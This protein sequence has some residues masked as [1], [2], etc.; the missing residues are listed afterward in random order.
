MN[1]ADGQEAA[2]RLCEIICSIVDER[3]GDLT[4]IQKVPDG[5]LRCFVLPL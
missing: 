5:N 4:R 1:K 2:D 3:L